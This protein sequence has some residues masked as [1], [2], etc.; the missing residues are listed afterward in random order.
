MTELWKKS[1]PHEIQHEINTI[2]KFTDKTGREASITACLKPGRDRLFVSN[3]AEGTTSGTEALGC[4]SRYGESQRVADVHTHPVD[5]DTI[6]ILPSQADF[7]STLVDSKVYKQRQ[8]SCVTSPNTPLT[9]C[10]IPKEIPDNHKLYQ[11][12]K[13]LD[14]A[15]AGSPGY[16]MDNVP[17]DFDIGFFN[18]KNGA[19]INK[20]HAKD[21]V[22]AAMGEST[23]DLRKQVTDLERAGFC[24]YVASFTT[25][26]RNDVVDE[27]KAQLRKRNLLGIIDY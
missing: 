19:R 20:P 25:P 21:V 9:E 23:K 18:P 22:K 8:I 26:T 24:E 15:I 14:N 16:Y 11:Y 6:G 12:E 7:Y 3:S 5:S 27:C 10:Y 17:R 13:A 2:N 4:D 1:I